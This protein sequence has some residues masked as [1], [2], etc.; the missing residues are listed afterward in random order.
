[1]A[2]DKPSSSEEEYFARQEAERRKKAAEAKAAQISQAERERLKREHWMRCP[3]CGFELQSIVYRGV[4]IDKCFN[5]GG[6]Y[7]DDGE[8]EKLAGKKGSL[9]Q[10][11][12]DL[13]K[14]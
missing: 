12:A 10:G 1:M 11:V 9:L 14:G 5:C 2:I 13:F 4:I 7:L 3:K 8:L 6:I